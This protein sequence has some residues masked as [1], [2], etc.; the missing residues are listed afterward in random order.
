MEKE[1]L[2]ESE[3]TALNKTD[4]MAMLPD[5]ILWKNAKEYAKQFAIRDKPVESEKLMSEAQD[6]YYRG[7]IEARKM[8]IG[9]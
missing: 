3:K 6:H 7:M 1:N 5:G 2:N 8:L 4:V 9:N